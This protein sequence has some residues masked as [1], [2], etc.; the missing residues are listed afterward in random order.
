MQ[1]IDKKN[2][3]FTAVIKHDEK[4]ITRLAKVQ[5]NVFQMGKKAIFVLS[6]VFLILLA[7]FGNLNL[8]AAGVL[9]FI[10]CMLWWFSDFPARITA[11]RMNQAIGKKYPKVEYYFYEKEVSI[12]DGKEWFHMPYSIVQRF[13]EDKEYWYLFLT[14]STSYMIPKDSLKKG[15]AQKFTTFIENRTGLKAEK[16]VAVMGLSIKSIVTRIKNS[17]ARKAKTKK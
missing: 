6:G 13:F 4:S 10:G 3:A 9:A 15:D 16:P 8:Q 1:Q 17:R 5:Y 2:T 11:V 14:T 12:T 7:V